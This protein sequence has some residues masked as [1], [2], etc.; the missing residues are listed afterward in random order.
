MLQALY[1]ISRC[2]DDHPR[3]A[4]QQVL[5]TPVVQKAVQSGKPEGDAPAASHAVKHGKDLGQCRVGLIALFRVQSIEWEV[6]CA[7]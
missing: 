1:L 2:G 7:H 3:F 5:W 6:I 4:G